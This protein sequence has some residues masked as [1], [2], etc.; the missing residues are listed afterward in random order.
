LVVS[1]GTLVTVTALTLGDL[2]L[3]HWSLA[4]N[5][6]VLALIAGLSLPPLVVAS[7][8]LLVVTILRVLARGAVLPVAWVSR[9]RAGRLAAASR[10]AAPEAATRQSPLPVSRAADLRPAEVRPP[11]VGS[12]A[13]GRDGST[14]KIAA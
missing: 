13:G 1:R 14:R 11:A 9:L 5:H 10:G 6:D 3:W 7:A 8:W 4:G 12:P 2:L